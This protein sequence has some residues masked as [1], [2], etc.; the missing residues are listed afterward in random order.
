M[1]LK[2]VFETF[3]AIIQLPLLRNADDRRRHGSLGKR[4]VKEYRDAKKAMER[5]Q[6]AERKAQMK[7]MRA[8]VGEASTKG[9]QSQTQEK[10]NGLLKAA[11]LKSALDQREGIGS[12]AGFGTST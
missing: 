8:R 1:P 10:G 3:S 12:G 4:R 7:V 2:K 6:D 11:V 9:K 5:A